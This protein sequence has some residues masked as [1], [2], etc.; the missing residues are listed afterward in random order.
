MKYTQMPACT[1]SLFDSEVEGHFSPPR[2]GQLNNHF[3]AG[4]QCGWQ[5]NGALLWLWRGWAQSSHRGALHVGVLASWTAS[6]AGI[7]FLPLCM[8]TPVHFTALQDH[9]AAVVFQVLCS[10][11]KAEQVLLQ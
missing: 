11:S 10:C 2:Q 6:F 7:L 9:W 1:V 8:P 5:E 4:Q 3:F